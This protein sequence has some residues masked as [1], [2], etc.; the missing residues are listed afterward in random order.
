MIFADVEI[1]VNSGNAAVDTAAVMAEAIT[2]WFA[3]GAASSAGEGKVAN[4]AEAADC[5]CASGSDA[6]RLMLVT[7][8]EADGRGSDSTVS[9]DATIFSGVSSGDAGCAKTASCG[10]PSRGGV[11]ASPVRVESWTE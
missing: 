9:D 5:C 7:A 1:G 11:A 6:E 8:P 4:G 2:I 3:S 10:E